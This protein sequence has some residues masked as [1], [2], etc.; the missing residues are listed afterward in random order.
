MNLKEGVKIVKFS[1][2]WCSP[3]KAL[4]PIW[5]EV[6][7]VTTVEMVEINVDTQSEIVSEFGIRAVPTVLVLNNGDTIERLSN[8]ITRD[9]LKSAIDKV[10]G[11]FVTEELKVDKDEGIDWL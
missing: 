7:N 8:G 3:C 11:L 4:K 2:D 10:E 9:T 5:D 6:S 1:A